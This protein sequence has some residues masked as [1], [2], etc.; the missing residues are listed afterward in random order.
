MLPIFHEIFFRRRLKRHTT[1][2]IFAWL[3]VKIMLVFDSELG[4]DEKACSYKFNKELVK[5]ELPW[6]LVY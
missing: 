6:S 2:R 4:L 3:Y 1:T 5:T